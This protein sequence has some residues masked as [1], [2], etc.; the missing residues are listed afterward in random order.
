MPSKLY[1]LPRLNLLWQCLMTDVSSR[2]ITLHKLIGWS[3]LFFSTLHTCAHMNNFVRFAKATNT[4]AFGF[5][6]A[7]FLTGPGAH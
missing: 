4:G 2:S 1:L 7:N 6:A 3:I 5:A